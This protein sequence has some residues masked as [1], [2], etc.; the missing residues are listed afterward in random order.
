M[1]SFG[2]VF[3]DEAY[4][5]KARELAQAIITGCCRMRGM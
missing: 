3:G 1:K 5:D 2:L 4:Q